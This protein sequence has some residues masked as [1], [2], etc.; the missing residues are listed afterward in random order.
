MFVR[1][2]KKSTNQ[3]INQFINITTWDT[4]APSIRAG[5]ACIKRMIINNYSPKAK[6]IA[7]NNPREEVEGMIQH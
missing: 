5:G 1:A 6:L 2:N 3:S 4:V 7:L